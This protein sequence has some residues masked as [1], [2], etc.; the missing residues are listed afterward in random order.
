MA[1]R[2]GLPAS[3]PSLGLAAEVLRSAEAAETR[4]A[5]RKRPEAV[6][7]LPMALRVEESS[8]GQPEP[9]IAEEVEARERKTLVSV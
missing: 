2:S 7:A 6:A 5:Q 1:A 8:P 4:P 3:P 9:R